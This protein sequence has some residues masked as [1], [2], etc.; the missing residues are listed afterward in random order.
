MRVLLADKLPDH[1][2]KRLAPPR[3]DVRSEPKLEGD[4]LAQRVS[5]WD[6][7]VVV[8]RSTKFQAQHARAGRSLQL[9]VRAGAGTDTIDK[10]ACSASA[11]LV[12]NCP[13]K[14]AVAV[15]ELTLGL[16]LALDRRIPDNVADLRAGT[17]AKGRYSVASGLRTRTLGILGMGSIGREVATRAAA[18]GMH[19]V[20]WSRSMTVEQAAA[21]GVSRRESAVQVAAEAD[22]L[23]VHVDGKL[24]GLVGREVLQALKPGALL[25]NTTRAGVV[26]EAALLEVI[27]QKGIRAG[28]DVF[29]GEPSGADGTIDH[30][31]A[32]HPNVYG[33]HHIGASTEEAQDAV[34]DEVCRIIEQFDA[35]G[36]VDKGNAANLA[37]T[38]AAT[39]RLD[40]RHL[41][42]VGVLAS[43][44]ACLRE[45]GI[46]VQ[47]ME[48]VVFPGGAAIARIQVASEPTAETL[49]R[50]NGLDHMLHVSAV[51][52]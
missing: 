22:V 13:G 17:W 46:N 4:S 39:H 20:A 14:N 33:T 42:R 31:L 10:E 41:D 49:A 18:F 32:R 43:V 24:K 2:Q 29:A 11:V 30:P 50:L 16:L 5:E 47:N 28:L 15:A 40:V 7:H 3:F 37:D 51:T 27:E 19:V 52:L 36:T 48:N 23:T 26:D 34:G 38:T 1:V 35:R 45:A 44:F 9:V 25:L 12:A 21:W 6:P 8:V